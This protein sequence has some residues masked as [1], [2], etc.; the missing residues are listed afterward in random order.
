MIQRIEEI[1]EVFQIYR[2]GLKTVILNEKISQI[3]SIL[4]TIQL[5]QTEWHTIVAV[6]FL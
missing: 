1:A 5:G 4:L 3:N 6:L 2:F